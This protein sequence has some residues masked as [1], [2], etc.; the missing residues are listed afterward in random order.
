MVD[1]VLG[2]PG[3][4]S[5]RKQTS[6]KGKHGSADFYVAQP[7]ARALRGTQDNCEIRF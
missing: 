1:K 2:R 4:F 5:S 7:G 3:Q 6:E